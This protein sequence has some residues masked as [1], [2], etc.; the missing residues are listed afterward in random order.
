MPSSQTLAAFAMASLVLLLV[1][2]PAVLFIVAR[3]IQHG[4]AAGVTSAVGVGAGNSVHVV[5][6]ALGLTAVLA[7]SATAF[8][9]VKVVGAGYLLWLAIGA[10]RGARGTPADRVDPAAAAAPGGST[11]RIL[12]DGAVVATFNPKIALF[13]LAFLPQFVDPQAGPIGVQIVVLGGLFVLLGI[14]TDTAYALA[15]GRA[16]RHLRGSARARRVQR[17]LTSTV[18]GALA[19]VALRSSRP[20]T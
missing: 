13:F 15:A 7:S 17:A 2:G 19:V 10:A 9:V 11:R 18:Y 8:T 4:R 5:A 6:A 3:S 20:V 14:C 1:P 16:A 12:R